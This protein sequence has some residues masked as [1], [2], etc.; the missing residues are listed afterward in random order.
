MNKTINEKLIEASIL[1]EAINVAS[2][3]KRLDITQ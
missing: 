3:F 1:M 2:I